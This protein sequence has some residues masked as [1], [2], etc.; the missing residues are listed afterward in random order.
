MALLWNESLSCLTWPA[1][2]NNTF[3][4]PSCLNTIII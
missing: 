4:W 3:M 1:C 2:S